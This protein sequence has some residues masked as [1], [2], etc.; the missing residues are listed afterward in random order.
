MRVY[1]DLCAIQRPLDD[2]T[3]LRIRAEAEAVLSVLALC[4]AESLDLVT[5]GAHVVENAKCPHP[6]RRT[7]V[8]DVLSLSGLYVEAGPGVL[9]RAER[10]EASGIKRLDAIPPAS[11][12]EAGADFFCTT[13]DQL[14][15]RGRSANTD[16]TS[17]VSPL[18]LVLHLSEADR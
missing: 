2:Q 1:L 10:L 7:H 18:E 8:A 14:L 11:A 15:R 5:S 17:V 16:P 13:D 6:D 4:E 12:I 9:R 3:Q